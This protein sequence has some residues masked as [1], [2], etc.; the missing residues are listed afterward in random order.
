[1]SIKVLLQ[2]GLYALGYS[3]PPFNES[4]ERRL[5]SVSEAKPLVCLVKRYTNKQTLCIFLQCKVFL[6]QVLPI[7]SAKEKKKFWPTRIEESFWLSA[8]CVP[9]DM[10]IASHKLHE[11][12]WNIL[13]NFDCKRK[14]ECGIP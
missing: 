10:I 1:M 12:S 11:L 14:K 6:Q 2:I 8:S 13:S 9:S 7:F 5:F 3:S 4:V